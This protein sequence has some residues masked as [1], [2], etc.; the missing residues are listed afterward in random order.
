MFQMER[1]LNKEKFTCDD[2]NITVWYHYVAFNIFNCAN[3]ANVRGYYVFCRRSVV[4]VDL[5]VIIET[6]RVGF[7]IKRQPGEL[8]TISWRRFNS[9]DTILV[10]QIMSV[11]SGRLNYS[12]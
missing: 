9:P 2:N 10:I 8:H 6:F 1:S 5:Y 7:Q 12:A 3:C 11:L 4:F